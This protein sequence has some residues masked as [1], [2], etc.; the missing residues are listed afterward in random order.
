MPSTVDWLLS[1]FA[2]SEELFTLEL[3]DLE[4]L[5]EELLEQGEPIVLDELHVGARLVGARF[6]HAATFTC[7][8]TV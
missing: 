1:A 3:Y 5:R 2:L 6:V 4:V 8:T 7:F